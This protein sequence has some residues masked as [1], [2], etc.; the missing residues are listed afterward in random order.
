MPKRLRILRNYH[1]WQ[2][3]RRTPISAEQIKKE[4]IIIKR[5]WINKMSIINNNTF[6]LHNSLLN[7][8]NGYTRYIITEGFF[9]Y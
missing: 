8:D 6:K 1:I 2:H 7:N 5:D 3:I 9:L 4:I